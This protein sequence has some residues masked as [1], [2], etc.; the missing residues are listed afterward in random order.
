ML[1]FLINH[2]E[3]TPG[4]N[5]DITALEQF[6]KDILHFDVCGGKSDPCYQNCRNIGRGDLFDILSRINKQYHHDSTISGT[7][8]DR[9]VFH[10]FS[11]GDRDNLS[12]PDNR[13]WSKVSIM[14]DI[15]K[16]MPNLQQQVPV[17]VFLHSQ[18]TQQL[19]NS[20]TQA[21]SPMG[22]VINSDNFMGL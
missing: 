4:I 3:Q 6:Y 5:S 18:P 15:D 13:N 1:Y 21:L 11:L 10:F 9:I 14:Q 7:E 17:V 12:T 19:T 8:Y 16:G 20:D 2:D 22:K